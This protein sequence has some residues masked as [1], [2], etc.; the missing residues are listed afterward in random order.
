MATSPLY[1]VRS[2]YV[3]PNSSHL[4]RAGNNGDYWSGRANSYRNAYEL[5]FYSS[6]VNPSKYTNR[7]YGQ[8]VR[9]VAGWE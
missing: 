7:Y 8:S 9:C 3:N 6:Y 4:D 5:Y 2:G 1:F